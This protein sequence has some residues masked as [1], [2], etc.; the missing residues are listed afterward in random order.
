MQKQKTEIYECKLTLKLT[1]EDADR[2]CRKAGEAEITVTELLQ[3]FIGDLIHGRHTGGSDERDCADMWFNRRYSMLC[4]NNDFVRYALM[5][6]N[7]DELLRVQESIEEYEEMLQDEEYEEDWDGLR[8]NVEAWKSELEEVYA[9]FLEW[10]EPKKAEKNLDEDMQRLAAWKEG[11]ERFKGRPV[12]Q[13]SE[14]GDW[15]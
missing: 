2:I 3:E 9:G 1:G 7:V 15:L 10:S 8:E 12:A 5:Y 13:E 6:Y 14:E 11:V 4:D